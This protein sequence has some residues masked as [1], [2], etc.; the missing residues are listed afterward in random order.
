MEASHRRVNSADT[1]GRQAGRQAGHS[2]VVVMVFL[3]K[4]P[5]HVK[6]NEMVVLTNNLPCDHAFNPH[7]GIM[8]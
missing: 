5:C 6:S 2:V 8:M 3:N 7:V 1:A 4:E